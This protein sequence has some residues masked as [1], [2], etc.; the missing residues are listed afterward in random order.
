MIHPTAIAVV[1]AVILSAYGIA[2]GI[3]YGF[4]ALVAACGRARDWWNGDMRIVQKVYFGTSLYTKTCPTCRHTWERM[5][6]QYDPDLGRTYD[7]EQTCTVCIVG[8]VEDECWPMAKHTFTFDADR[9]AFRQSI[10]ELIDS[11]D[12][13]AAQGPQQVSGSGEPVVTDTAL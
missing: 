8:T 11:Q 6:R 5:S 7:R 4:A 10:K 9:D 1:P 13:P 12:F 3:A 2:Y